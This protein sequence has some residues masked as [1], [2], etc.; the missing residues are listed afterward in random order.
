M[1]RDYRRNKEMPV[2][3]LRKGLKSKCHSGMIPHLKSKNGEV[4]IESTD[5]KQVKW[6]EEF[7]K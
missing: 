4:K 7:K 3:K 2:A 1:N 5:S 6:F